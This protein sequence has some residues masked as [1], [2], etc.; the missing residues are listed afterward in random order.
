VVADLRRCCDANRVTNRKNGRSYGGEWPRERFWEHRITY[1]P[2]E[3][4]IP[5]LYGEVLPL[6]NSLKVEL[7]DQ[8]RLVNQFLGLERRT[9]RQARD[10]IDYAP[11]GHDDVANAA[12]GALVRAAEGLRTP[13]S[14]TYERS[15]QSYL[16]T[17]VTGGLKVRSGAACKQRC[18]TAVCS[19]P[20]AALLRYRLHPA[21]HSF[22]AL[23]R[24]ATDGLPA[25][26]HPLSPP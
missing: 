7:L 16:P 17:V 1:E 2:A 24:V 4:L 11:G 23:G 5:E 22:H 20:T 25:Q 10:T 9:S 13:V 14:R 8:P 3:R 19:Q 21:A 15:A 26:I 18:S 12:A 6:L